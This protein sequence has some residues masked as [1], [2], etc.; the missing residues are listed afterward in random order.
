MKKNKIIYVLM[1]LVY[2]TACKTEDEKDSTT[3]RKKTSNSEIEKI[4]TLFDETSFSSNEEQNLLKELE[5]CNPSQKD[6][7]NYNDPACHPKF[8]KFFKYNSKKSLKDAFVLLI[9]SKVQGFP[10]RRVLIFERENGQLVKVNGF[11]ANLIEKRKTKSQID[12]IVL[13]F[14]DH[15]GGG[16]IVFYNCLYRWEDKHYV[17]Q[18]VEQI[19]DA[20]I[21]PMYQ[22][23]MNN[24][25]YSIISSHQ[26]EF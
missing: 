24:E 15:L 4:E 3:T 18:K 7:T 2:L 16:D 23:S 17:F 26:M 13:R 25:I 5:I 22:D 1:L 11:V 8:F 6:K 9:K 21:K 14:N 10:L 12:D 19:N 20:N